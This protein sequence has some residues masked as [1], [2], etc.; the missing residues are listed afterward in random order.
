MPHLQ[1]SF[2]HTWSNSGLEYGLSIQNHGLGPARILQV[3][4]FKNN[5]PFDTKCSDPIKR[6]L[7]ATLGDT[8]P[9]HVRV[10]SFPKRNYSLKANAEYRLVKIE[11]PGMTPELEEKINVPKLD[12]RIEYE[13][14]YGD[15]RVLDT[16]A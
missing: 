6:I 14:F 16:R 9:F 5:E 1:W 2:D 4:L 12:V 3:E 13:S 11:F 15:S 7:V 10:S 8:A